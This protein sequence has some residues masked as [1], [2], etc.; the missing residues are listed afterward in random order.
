MILTVIIVNYNVQHFL[1][2]CLNSVQKACLSIDSEIFVVDNNSV[3]ASTSMVKE[4]FSD[5]QLIENTKNVGFSKANN[6]AIKKAKGKYVLLLNPDTIV[7]ED[8][9]EKIIEHLD[10]NHEVGAVGVKMIDGNGKFLPESK[11][12]LPTPSVAF[13]KISGFSKLFPRSKI[14]AKYHLGY[15]D[16]NEIHEVD[17]LSG[18]FMF[19]RKKTID[20]VGLL[21][22]D[23]FMYG[24]DIDMSYRIKLAGYKNVYFPKTTIIH[25]KG[26]S[27]KKGSINY[28]K[29]FYNAMIIFARKH[30]S[31]KNASIFSFLINLA[32]Y[33]RASIAIF[34]LAIKNTILPIFDATSIFIGYKIAIPLWENYKFSENGV[35]PKEFLSYVV[36]SYIALWISFLYFNKGYKKP[37][38]L[39][40]IIRS[41][42]IGTLFILLFYS[43]LNEEMRFSRILII[44]G[45][46]WSSISIVLIR[47][48]FHFLKIDGY[49]LNSV[50]KKKIAIVGENDEFERITLMLKQFEYKLGDIWH[51]SLS[52][53]SFSSEFSG[54]IENISDI[55][56][57]NNI[58]EIIFCTKYISSQKI[59]DIMHKMAH[60]NVNYKI[61]SHES[62]SIIGSDSIDSVN[63]LMD[64]SNNSIGKVA[65][66]RKKRIFDIL[67]SAILLIISPA[68]LFFV[69]NTKGLFINISK[70]L[71]GKM[72]MV[73]YLLAK[74]V[75]ISNLPSIKN[76]VLNPSDYFSSKKIISKEVAERINLQIG[77]A[78]V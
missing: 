51:I 39:K 23:Y 3:D 49:S 36:P 57:L 33:F 37:I 10:K 73:G 15:L 18:A 8:T 47:I 7:E 62:F 52:K 6:Q 14:F 76:G 58:D 78:H 32:I 63:E 34:N 56:T 50:K 53:K 12:S 55:T 16:N 72:T 29:V 13:Y 30:F 54:S 44:F 40:N 60:I 35:Y 26:E 19:L 21:D 28:L 70:V 42:I 48:I 5:V 46:V 2:Q 66:V 41:L 75:D 9:F 25:Y 71:S 65:N 64:I 68:A 24:E 69:K 11:R 20:Q 74:N 1:E 17:I 61:A 77:R 45:F 27:T 59:I 67:F 22:E 43:L 38:S 4:K 31:K